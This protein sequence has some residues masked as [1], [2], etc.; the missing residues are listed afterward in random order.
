VELIE[1]IRK[2]LE[3]LPEEENIK[4]H[5]EQTKQAISFKADGNEK[6]KKLLTTY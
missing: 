1:G 4:K 5:F 3:K 6:F 2:L